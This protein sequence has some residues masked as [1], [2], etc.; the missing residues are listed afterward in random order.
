M[1]VATDADVIMMYM[2]YVTHLEGL[3]EIWVKKDSYLPAHAISEALAAK[4]SV[5]AADLTYILLITYILT[6]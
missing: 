4:Y 6:G 3:E 2:Y 5:N 1:V